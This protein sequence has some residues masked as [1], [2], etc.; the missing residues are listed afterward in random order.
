MNFIIK[1]SR[2]AASSQFQCGLSST[3]RMD[4]I[5]PANGRIVGGADAFSHRWPWQVS[6]ILTRHIEKNGHAEKK[7]RKKI[8]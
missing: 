6:F 3:N 1:I 5:F 2:V 4:Q 8:P 7:T